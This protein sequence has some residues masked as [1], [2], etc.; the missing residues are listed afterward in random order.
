MW[1]KKELIDKPAEVW[2]VMAGGVTLQAACDF[3]GVNRRTGR[4]WRQ[5]T[6][7][8]VPRKA[9]P[10]SGRYLTLD[11]RLQM[12][13]LRL[14]GVRVRAIATELDRSPA[15]VSRELHATARSP[16][17]AGGEYAPYAAQKRAELR[18]L[19]PRSA[20]STTRN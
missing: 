17:L 9:A 11:E 6:G 19:G 14:A 3:V 20:T 7:G 4:R 2:G 12:G 5:A 18:G 13:D 1:S 15:T 8:R 16:G 10:P